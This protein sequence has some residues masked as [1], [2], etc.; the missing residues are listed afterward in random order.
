MLMHHSTLQHPRVKWWGVYLV[1]KCNECILNKG[2]QMRTDLY[3]LEVEP[4]LTNGA[5]RELT[6]HVYLVGTG[7]SVLED[8]P[9]TSRFHIRKTNENIEDH[10]VVLEELLLMHCR[11]GIV[12]MPN[13]G[14]HHW[15]ALESTS[16]RLAPM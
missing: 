8:L 16:L 9:R 15:S 4:N 10:S 14:L 1:K 7:G 12:K 2:A 11:L 5:F 6:R 3:M 13:S